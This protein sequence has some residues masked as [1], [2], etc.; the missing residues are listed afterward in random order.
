MEKGGRRKL[1]A[2]REYREVHGRE[3]FH[4][5]STGKKEISRKWL[6]EDEIGN[7]ERRRGGNAEERKEI[8]RTRGHGRER[9]LD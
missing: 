1:P 2:G 3:R 9:E 6:T 5:N 4:K 8:G 7:S